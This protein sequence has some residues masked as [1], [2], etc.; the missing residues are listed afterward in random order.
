MEYC[1]RDTDEVCLVTLC[2][3][4]NLHRAVRKQGMEILGFG[5]K[6]P[7]DI[8]LEDCAV[9]LMHTLF[10][11]ITPKRTDERE[12]RTEDKGIRFYFRNR[13]L[14]TKHNSM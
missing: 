6:L 3:W 11:H 1:A 7:T 8:V 4:A 9:R 14:L 2:L 10:D 12:K 5:F 13:N